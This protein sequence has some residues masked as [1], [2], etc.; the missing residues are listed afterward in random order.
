MHAKGIRKILMRGKIK[1]FWG[2][3]AY[4]KV[5]VPLALFPEN[6]PP[7]EL[8]PYLNEDGYY[9]KDGL[10]YNLYK[11]TG[12]DPTNEVNYN[13]I[14]FLSKV[15]EENYYQWWEGI[16]LDKNTHKKVGEIPENIIAQ[17][18]KRR[19]WVNKYIYG[20]DSSAVFQA[21]NIAACYAKGPYYDLRTDNLILT[22]GVRWFYPDRKRKFCA[23]LAN[24]CQ[25]ARYMG[26][27]LRILNGR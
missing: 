3:R 5:A 2:E 7:F 24:A 20:N 16:L 8:D 18:V 19:K 10:I 6:P 22:Y 27:P 9:I 21:L 4:I 25:Y 23:A 17:Y 1:T 12:P 26:H 14:H 15:E 13:E 11:V